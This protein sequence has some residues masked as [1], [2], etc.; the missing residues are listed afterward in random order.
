MAPSSPPPPPRRCQPSS[1]SSVVLR[2]RNNRTPAEKRKSMSNNK[3]D[4]TLGTSKRGRAADRGHATAKRTE[5]KTAAG[6]SQPA[7][8]QRLPAPTFF[9]AEESSRCRATAS[10]GKGGERSGAD[11]SEAA[12]VAEPFFA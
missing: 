1:S 11:L 5:G 2:K 6:A 4:S 10:R 7:T 12:A 9:P 8:A 3:Q